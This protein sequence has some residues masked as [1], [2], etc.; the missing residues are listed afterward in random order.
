MLTG[1]SSGAYYSSNKDLL[2]FGSAILNSQ[3]L[4]PATTRA[5]MK[6]K[7]STSSTGAQLGAP[8]EIYRSDN[9]T[10]AGRL[11]EVYT[12]SGNLASYNSMIA[13]VPDYN[14]TV[15]VNVAGNE[16]S[17][18]ISTMFM[19]KIVQTLLPELERIG[20]ENSVESYEDTY[21]DSATNSSLAIK[22]DDGPGLSVKSLIVRGVDILATHGVLSSF[23]APSD[24]STPATARLYPTNVES[25]ARQ[26]W[27]AMYTTLT[28]A[29]MAAVDNSLFWNS[30]SC[31]AWEALDRFTYQYKSTDEIVFTMQDGK[32][33][34]AE[35]P[36]FQV[37]LQACAANLT[38][39]SFT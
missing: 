36:I 28:A 14:I 8:W 15:A 13:L 16:T 7:I 26:S 38:T 2:A 27:R 18:L 11:I 21:R 5:W 20:R 1:S 25:G 3:L 10:A 23:G 35:L 6:P 17:E 31:Q 4:S 29:E 39:R 30:G 12:K 32:A 9:L 33:V 34:S 19:S 37:S 22:I 24:D